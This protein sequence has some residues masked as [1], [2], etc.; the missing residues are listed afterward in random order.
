MTPAE[1]LDRA[2][3]QAVK[4]AWKGRQVRPGQRD[5]LV[6]PVSVAP[7]AS[8]LDE[9][10]VPQPAR[11]ALLRAAD[12]VMDGHWELF[13]SD[14]TDF[15]QPDWFLDHAS[16]V[17]AP[18]DAYA[19]SIQHR[20]EA[21]VGNI[22]NVWEPSRHHHLTV[23]AAAYFVSGDD[24]Y[25][26][27]V[28]AH[29][30]SWWAQNPF[31]SGVHWTSGIEIGIRLISWVWT[32]RLLDGWPGARALFEENPDALRQLAHH[33]D[34]LST[35]PSTGS[36]ANNHVVAEAAGLLAASLAFPWFDRSARWQD[37]GLQLLTD[38]VAQQTFPSGLNRELAS[39]YH[40]LTLELALVGATE[41]SL[42]G[43]SVP[44]RLWDPTV[45]MI[46]ALAAVVDVS[47]RPARQGDSDDG[48]VLVV[49]DPAADR[50]ASILASGAALFGSLDWWP[51]GRDG[52]VRTALLAGSLT[53]RPTVSHRPA[54]RPSSFADAGLT[55]LRTA[56]GV[57]PETWCRVDGGPHGFL[58]IAAHAH[59][60]AL[61]IELRHGGVDVLADPGTFCY[62]GEPEW[63][64][65]FRGTRGHN[66]LELGG[67]DQ[68]ES[69]GPF[70]WTR[71]AV[72]HVLSTSGLDG[73]DT[74][75]WVAE[76]DGYTVLDPPAVHRRSVTLDRGSA[77]VE[78]L[79]RV[80]CQGE[81][82]ARLF[83][84]LGPLVEV[85]LEGAV[86]EMSWPGGSATAELDPSLSWSAHRG[87]EHPPLG[88]YSP[89]FGRKVPSTTLVG[90]GRAGRG[91]TLR[92]VLDLRAG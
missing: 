58:S 2:R 56:A 6:L 77:R 84:H 54:A 30:R 79:D 64:A 34:F 60:D 46:D 72:T 17:R 26:E 59:A 1:I 67:V 18:S 82:P 10:V 74:A 80:E 83:L 53:S 35:L 52:D 49:D 28:D 19:F 12:R 32:R 11:L 41:L 89:G 50:W 69:G 68:S 39:D 78:V 16:G 44:A 75:G 88:W 42:A 87:E 27:R 86:A 63:R 7:F 43:R 65:L 14:R 37:Q 71:H 38:E 47:G 40:G 15:V 76:H 48:L 5:P 22:K 51:P 66:T 57:V 81:H 91:R 85:R 92:T 23:L 36:S 13:G 3:H 9:V 61:A 21:V 55:L 20:D 25:A 62:H 24:R 4:T 73:G 90:S 45:R 70:L 31:L 29:L 8:P 33:Q